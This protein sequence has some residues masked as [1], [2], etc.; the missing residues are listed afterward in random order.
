[1]PESSKREERQK[2]WESR[3]LYFGCLN[4]LS[5]VA[6]GEEGSQCSAQKKVYE[7]NCAESWVRYFNTR[8]VLGEQ[9]KEV[10]A[11]V[12]KQ[13]LEAEGKGFR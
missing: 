8:R 9:Q 5:I 7:K 2:C 3:D 10:L 12:E 1:M 6:P 11:A 4:S 13:R